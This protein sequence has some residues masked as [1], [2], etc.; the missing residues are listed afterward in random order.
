MFVA[1]FR[2]LGQIPAISPLKLFGCVVACVCLVVLVNVQICMRVC[3]FLFNVGCDKLLLQ[4]G[5]IFRTLFE[6]VCFD[7]ATYQYCVLTG[8]PNNFGSAFFLVTGPGSRCK[9]GGWLLR[10]WPGPPQLLIKLCFGSRRLK[11][12][13]CRRSTF[14][15]ANCKRIVAQHL[16]WRVRPKAAYLQ[17]VKCQC[18]HFSGMQ[19][20][21]CI[22]KLG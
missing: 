21:Q 4:T 13:W 19:C 14:W 12:C 10:L 17:L 15:F 2:A 22:F 6:V 5:S 20:F 7:N 8:A 18:S 1:H 11:I 16:F 3:M 9:S